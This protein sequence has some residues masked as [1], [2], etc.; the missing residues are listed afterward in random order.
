MAETVTALV[1]T[2][3][4]SSEPQSI[5]GLPGL[6]STEAEL[7]VVPADIGYDIGELSALAADLGFEIEEAEYERETVADDDETKLTVAEIEAGINEF[8]REE[9]IALT[10]DDRKGAREAAAARLA[11][12]DE[13]AEG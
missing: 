6:W 11:E 13:E 12:L 9:L 8:T 7:S 5:P 2:S 4:A 3:A 1:L 10:S